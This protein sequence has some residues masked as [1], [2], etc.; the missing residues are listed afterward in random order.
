MQHENL[1]KYKANFHTKDIE[2]K[3]P[4]QNPVLEIFHAILKNPA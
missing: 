2:C 3:I 4:A 1:K